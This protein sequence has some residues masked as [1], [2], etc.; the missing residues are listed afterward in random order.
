MAKA[1]GVVMLVFV[2][3]FLAEN[4]SAGASVVTS[5][6]EEVGDPLVVR[7]LHLVNL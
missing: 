5:R 3:L 1:G 7:H 6:A 2:A 4:L